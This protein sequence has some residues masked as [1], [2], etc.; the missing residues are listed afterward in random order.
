MV[1]SRYLRRE[2]W[3]ATLVTTTVLLLVLVSNQVVRYLHWVAEGRLSID[4]L[5]KMIS[6]QAPILLPFLLPLG[7]YLG[8]LF[9][10]GRLY[11][12]NEMCILSTSGMSQSRILRITMVA[13]LLVTSTVAMLMWHSKPALYR[14]QQTLM[15]QQ[16]SSPLKTLLPGKFQQF[17]GGKW[18]VYAGKQANDPN[19]GLDD[20]FVVRLSNKKGKASPPEFDII[21]A[22]QVRDETHQTQTHKKGR[23]L[24]FHNGHRYQGTPGE[25]N[26]KILSYQQLGLELPPKLH[27]AKMSA[28]KYTPSA[29]L[30]Q[31]RHTNRLANVELQ[32]RL[33]IP[34]SVIILGLLAVPLSQLQPRQGRYRKFIPALLVYIIYMQLLFAARTWSKEAL[35]SLDPLSIFALVHC[36][37]LLFALL[38]YSRK[39]K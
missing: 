23:F 16:A 20:V 11:A 19:G 14:Y 32:W 39:T 24:V 22:K 7:L 13:V 18:V 2:I 37:G 1:I 36:T 12:D 34:T 31:Q 30:W 10:Y 26:Y 8:I 33:A 3:G 25:Q 38:L 6:I 29:T 9:A 4:F 27:L 35:F 21:S 28:E 5:M 15:T 17:D